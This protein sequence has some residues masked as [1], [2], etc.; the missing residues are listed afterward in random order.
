MI[1]SL[2]GRLLTK[3]TELAVIDCGGVG[4]S[5]HMSLT[6]LTRLGPEGSE[7]SVL[8]H[9]HLTQDALRL[10]GFIEASERRL[11]EV[12]INTSGVGPKLALSILSLLSPGDLADI[13]ARGDKGMLVQ[14]PGIGAKKAERLLLELKGRLDDVVATPTPRRAASAGPADDLLAA[15]VSLGFAPKDAERAA[16]HALEARPG[17]TDLAAL[18]REALRASARAS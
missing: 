15:L 11:F 17:E 16:R 3:D 10:F 9:T 7:V 14:V 5:V 18:V 2:R 1:A 12:L 13:V 8:V 6:S 4:Y